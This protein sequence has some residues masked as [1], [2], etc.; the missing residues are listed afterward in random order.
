MMGLKFWRLRGRSSRKCLGENFDCS[1]KSVNYVYVLQSG[2]S[3]FIHLCNAKEILEV[4]VL[5]SG[6]LSTRYTFST[7][8]SLNH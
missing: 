5:F 7:V 4:V 1:T 3:V 8:L 2:Q 6:S